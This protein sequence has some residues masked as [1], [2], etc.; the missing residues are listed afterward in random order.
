MLAASNKDVGGLD[1]AMNDA[2]TVRGLQ[3]LGDFDRLRQQ[4]LYV[5][6]A[7]GDAVFQR[8]AVE[9]FHGNERLLAVL[10]D[11]IDGANVRMIEGRGSASLAAETLH[12]LRIARHFVG[13]EFEGDEAAEVGVFRLVDDAHAATAQLLDNSVMRDGLA[14]HGVGPW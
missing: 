10:A 11:F 4:A 6:G 2:L 14:D 13:K 8:Y 9:K 5:H 7:A 3:S 12:R 1:V